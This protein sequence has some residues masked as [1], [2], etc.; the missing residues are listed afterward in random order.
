MEQFQAFESFFG[1]K[2]RFAR[3]FFID[4]IDIA[5]VLYYTTH[6]KLLGDLLCMT[7]VS[8]T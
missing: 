8:Q 6:V 7:S 5:A 1:L 3:N 4:L 2:L